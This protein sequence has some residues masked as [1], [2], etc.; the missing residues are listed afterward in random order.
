ML[1]AYGVG[2]ISRPLGAIFFGYIGDVYGRKTALFYSL[3]GMSICTL[4]CGVLPS[5]EMIGVSASV[6]FFLIRICQGICIGG[7][8]Q[9]GSVF[10]IEHF[11]QKT[12]AAFGAFFATSNGI[13][14]LLATLI[15]LGFLTINS[16]DPHIWRYPFILGAL[17]GTVG[18]Y[19]RKNIP[20][21]PS[22]KVTEVIA[23]PIKSTFKDHKK[24]CI[25]VFLYFALISSSTHFC[26][27]FVNVFLNTFVEFA[28][29]D[30][31]TFACVSTL[32]LIVVVV[33]TGMFLKKFPNSLEK[34]IKWGMWSTL[35]LA[36]LVMVLM[37]GGQDLQITL[38]L[39]LLASFTGALCGAAPYFIAIHFRVTNRYSGSSLLNNLAQGFVGGFFP[40]IGFF[41]LSKTNQAIFPGLYISALALV[42][43]VFNHFC[44]GV[45]LYAQD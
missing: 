6:L 8:S 21:T 36:P 18:F 19:I 1:I 13:G 22:F 9:G 11:W 25:R 2:F 29:T 42:F 38:A 17:V 15:S 33:L 39:I 26:F 12:P 5:Y 28:K 20:E 3:L 24:G 27:T 35:I 4:I 37:Q 31:L 7:E 40:S 34:I 23:N 32:L 44:K 30:A 45:K 16:S 41:L 43:I 10:I 14:A